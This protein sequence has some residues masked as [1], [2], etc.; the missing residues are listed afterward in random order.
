MMVPG[1]GKAN[2]L[3]SEFL[4]EY[5]PKGSVHKLLVAQAGAKKAA[6]YVSRNGNSFVRGHRDWL[7]YYINNNIELDDFYCP[8]IER[9]EKQEPKT[10]EN[11]IERLN[12]S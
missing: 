7:C 8:K 3:L 5:N 9:T 10:L 12:G 4:F 2:D 6:W 11:I 1:P